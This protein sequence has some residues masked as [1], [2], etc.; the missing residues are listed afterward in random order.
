VQ[1]ACPGHELVLHGSTA[2]LLEFV[3]PFAREGVAAGEP[4]LLLVRPDVG[5]AV[6]RHVEH[7]PHLRILPAL[8]QP[9]RGAADLRAAEALVAGHALSASCVRLLNQEPTVPET[10]WH[11]WRRLE[12]AVNLA[13]SR[14]DASVVCL[15]DRHTLGEGK[16]DDLYATH[17]TVGCGGEHR[18][19]DRYQ[20]PSA[21]IRR[22]MDAPPDEVEGS[23]PSAELVD[24]AP[25]IARTAVGAS[26]IHSGLPPHEVENMVLATH[27]A[28]ANA[29]LHGRPPVVLRLWV[30]PGRLTVTVTD[31]GSGPT[32]P[33]LGLL[34]P[35]NP[36]GSGLG[37]WISHQLVDITHRRHRDGYTVRMTATG[38]CASTN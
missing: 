19:N 16:V 29:G 23:P 35:D 4:T 22:H 31:T 5:A 27:E 28:V 1:R 17:P 3:V 15:Y 38:S 25:F 18:V 11:E 24:P 26:A 32:N 13:F 30:R 14:H 34:P 8:G 9:G 36:N 21:F 20:D 37:L 33:F 12:A 10:H 2:E 6:R 7:A